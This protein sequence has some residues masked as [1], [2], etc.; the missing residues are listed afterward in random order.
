MPPVDTDV[1]VDFDH[2]VFVHLSIGCERCPFGRVSL[3]L[4]GGFRLGT[5]S[6]TGFAPARL[7]FGGHCTASLLVSALSSAAS[8]TTTPGCPEFQKGVQGQVSPDRLIM[9]LVS[10]PP[11]SQ[12]QYSPD[13]KFYWDGQQ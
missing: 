12:P 3:V 1:D 9:R 13:K 2:A 6:R 10:Q 5:A 7:R 8:V 4:P 11:S